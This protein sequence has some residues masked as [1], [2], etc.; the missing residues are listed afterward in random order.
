MDISGYI[1]LLI[2]FIDGLLF[3]LAIKKGIVS[4]I[5]LIIAFVLASYAGLSFI[6]KISFSKVSSYVVKFISNNIDKAPGLISLGHV[7]A[8]TIVTVLFLIGLGIGIWKG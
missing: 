1:L 2:T 3:G 8:I 4:A 5:L 7:G 6:P